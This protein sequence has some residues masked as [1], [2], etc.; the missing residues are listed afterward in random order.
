MMLNQG[1]SDQ[2]G[3]RLR[4]IGKSLLLRHRIEL[5]DQIGRHGQTESA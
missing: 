4:A 1:R 3:N 5:P 2:L